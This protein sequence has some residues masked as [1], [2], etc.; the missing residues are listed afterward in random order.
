M[1]VYT[2]GYAIDLEAISSTPRS[3]AVGIVEIALEE[4]S[5]T[6]DL[7]DDDVIALEVIFGLRE[8]SSFPKHIDLAVAFRWFCK[9]FGVV[10]PGTMCGVYV[11]EIDTALLNGIPPFGFPAGDE[12]ISHIA[13]AQVK[14]ERE[15]LAGCVEEVATIDTVEDLSWLAD[16]RRTFLRWLDICIEK[17]KDLVVTQA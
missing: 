5:A 16:E 14:Q 6:G 17:D 7:V 13:L 4:L 11:L 2:T 15:K 12:N 1:T 8:V 10:L 9:N 3:E